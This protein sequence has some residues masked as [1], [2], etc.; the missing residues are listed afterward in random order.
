V[1]PAAHRA[2]SQVHRPSRPEASLL[3]VTTPPDG[4]EPDTRAPRSQSH[5]YSCLISVA[6][7]VQWSTAAP[8]VPLGWCP[9]WINKPQIRDIVPM[10]YHER[11]GEALTGRRQPVASG[12]P[13]S[14]AQSLARATLPRAVQLTSWATHETCSSRA[15]QLTSRESMVSGAESSVPS[16]WTVYIVRTSHPAAPNLEST[17]H[18]TATR[19][20]TIR[21]TPAYPSQRRPSPLRARPYGPPPTPANIPAPA[22]NTTGAKW[23]CH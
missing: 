15:V 16:E 18:P 13:A 19:P 9:D 17:P 5:R 14:A 20:T 8:A 1:Q 11:R 6:G 10:P 3:S 2:A 7:G 12:R 4:I 23:R 22:Q 21:S